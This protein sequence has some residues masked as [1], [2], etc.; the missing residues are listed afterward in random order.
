M[1]AYGVQVR[2]LSLDEIQELARW[3]FNPR[4]A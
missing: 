4:L 3:V 1:V 2:Q